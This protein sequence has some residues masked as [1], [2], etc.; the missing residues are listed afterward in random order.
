MKT[1]TGLMTAACA[2]GLM[3]G[4]TTAGFAADKKPVKAAE[5]PVEWVKSIPLD[6]A[7]QAVQ[8]AMD[9]CR[10]AGKRGSYGVMDMDGNMKVLLIDDNANEVGQHALMHKMYTSL[11]LQQ[12]TW[13]MIARA[14]PMYHIRAE[15]DP[16]ADVLDKIAP[17]GLVSPGGYALKIGDQFVGV[18]GAGGTAQGYGPGSEAKCAEAGGDWFESVVNGKPFVTD[19]KDPAYKP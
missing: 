19:P 15:I 17:G 13:P 16:E 5:P 10:K 4:G 6:L 7:M 1:L 11:L 9:T 14:D 2:L 18:I 3:A 8:V 12:T